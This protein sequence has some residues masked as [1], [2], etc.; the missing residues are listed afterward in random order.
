MPL[1]FFLSF[2]KDVCLIEPIES[3]QLI[4]QSGERKLTFRNPQPGLKIALKTLENRGAIPSQLKNTI[5][6]IDGFAARQKFDYYLKKFAS[7]GWLCYSILAD[8]TKIATAI[9]LTP[10]FQFTQQKVPADTKYV[11]SGFAY[12]HQ[13]AGQTLLESPLS[14]AQ[15][16]LHWK[17]AALLAALSIPQNISQLSS[18][19][20]DVSFEIAEQF[21]SLLFI[22]K[23][24]S[25]VAENGKISE[26]EN[27]ALAQWEFHDLLFHT[28]SRLGRHTNPYGGTF[29]FMGKIEPLPAVKPSLPGDLIDLYKPDLDNLKLTDISFTQVLETRKSIREWGEKPITVHQLGEF[30]YRSARI[31]NIFVSEFGEVSS[32]PYPAGGAIYELEIYPVVQSCQGLDSGLYHYRPDSH[33]ICRLSERNEV[34]EMLLKDAGKSMGVDGM[35][36][37]LLVISARFQRIAWK[38]QSIAYA[39]VLKHVGV[40]YQTMYLVATAMKLAPCSLG[41]GNSDLFVKTVGCDYY[42]ETS[43]GEFALG[44][45]SFASQP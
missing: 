38:Y 9:P 6:E 37:I 2:R 5:H 43:V 44:S 27:T 4:L 45:C 18:E 7:L 32:R 39:L 34:V 25:E 36:P 26:T 42:A 1:E 17:G 30:L 10:D 14:F 13:V 33:Q 19:I 11:L 31:K 3:E 22:N 29:Q 12:S 41:G 20:P 15:I 8:E 21:I 35:P 40:L 28:R 24:L 16:T 23:M